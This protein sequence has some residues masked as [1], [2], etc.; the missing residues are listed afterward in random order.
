MRERIKRYTGKPIVFSILLNATFL[1]V[2][3]L[4][5]RPY[6]EENDDVIIS[7]IL[8][9]VY[10]KTDYHLV[11]INTCL[12]VL[13]KALYTV[14]PLIKWHTVFQYLLLFI[15]FTAITWILVKHKNHG[16]WLALLF[17]LLSFYEGYVSLQYTKTAAVIVVAGFLLI[18]CGLRSNHKLQYIIGIVL[19]LFGAL[20]RFEIFLLI[21]A[22]M[23]GVGLWELYHNKEEKRKYILRSAIVFAILFVLVILSKYL[24]MAQYRSDAAWKEFTEFNDARTDLL[25]YRYDLLDYEE[26]AEQLM[27]LHVSENDALLYLTWQFADDRVFNQQLITDLLAE[28][29]IRKVDIQLCKAFVENLYR[30]FFVVSAAMLGGVL[31]LA[32]IFFSERKRFSSL[33][34]YL[35]MIL[36]AGLCY[37]Q[38]SG[39][40]S[41]RL[42]FAAWFAYLVIVLLYS[43]ME[44]KQSLSG[45]TAILI[46]LN[47]GMLFTSITDYHDYSRSQ[48][49]P[50]VLSEYTQSN[51]DNLYLMDTFTDQNSYK[52]DVFKVYEPGCYANRAYFGGWLCHSPIYAQITDAFGY[53]NT[54]EALQENRNDNVYLID[55]CY[56][57]EKLLYIE[58]HY[59]EKI[60]LQPVENVG[61]YQVYRIV[62]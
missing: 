28:N 58:E 14:L 9:G 33:W 18:F 39:R 12:G 25:D 27:A 54:F 21:T 24:D 17:L 40:F 23:F 44:I 43:E 36:A 50:E 20:Y 46:F 61:G 41:H 29:S 8:E 52:Y 13:L 60:S 57:E 22:F 34:I 38:Y 15:S 53:Q 7:F 10:G 2:A 45:L 1:L 19:C 11:Y 30:E 48:M 3:I 35:T 62:Q 37:F 5:F 49:E 16:K 55:N 31:L 26:Y 56:P 51:A 59:G 6:F 4:C 47:I 42:V 32:W